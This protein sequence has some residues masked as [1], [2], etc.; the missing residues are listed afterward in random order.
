MKQVCVNI[1][2]RVTIIASLSSI[3]APTRVAHTHTLDDMFNY[4]K[5]NAC[6][7]GKNRPRQC[8]QNKKNMK[9]AFGGGAMG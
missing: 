1:S 4:L 9:Y 8:Q 6:I 5:V 3:A 2:Q 7:R